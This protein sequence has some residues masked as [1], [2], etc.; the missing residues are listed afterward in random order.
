[1]KSL[2][3]DS[4]K[5]CCLLRLRRWYED[6][7]W[8]EHSSFPYGG[9]HGNGNDPEGLSP[10][11]APSLVREGDMGRTGG[12]QPSHYF[13]RVTGILGPAALDRH[14]LLVPHD[15]ATSR[16]DRLSVDIPS[17]HPY[18][19]HSRSRPV[20]EGLERAQPLQRRGPAHLLCENGTCCRSTRRFAQTRH[21]CFY[22]RL[23]K[24]AWGGSPMKTHH[25]AA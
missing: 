18:R 24:D 22:S 8:M 7:R 9:N 6:H 19:K 1:M 12:L 3:L 15:R 4:S 23:P 21:Y 20:L 11:H 17:W 16:K 14:S 13:L 10:S 2:A 25:A 5:V